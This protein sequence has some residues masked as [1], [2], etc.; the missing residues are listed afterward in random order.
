MYTL[1]PLIEKCS[2][3][4]WI[5]IAAVI[6]YVL[7]V[8]HFNGK[9]NASW[10]KSP[11]DEEDLRFTLR[12][13]NFGLFCFSF[14][15]L[16][17]TYQHLLNAVLL[18]NCAPAP[19]LGEAGRAM[20]AFAL[21]K[22]VELGDTFFLIIRGKNVR[23]IHSFHHASV[24]LLT[25]Y[26]FVSKA[27]IGPS[28]V[29]MNYFVHVMLYLYYVAASLPIGV[30]MAKKCGPVVTAMQIIQMVFGFAISARALLVKLT[31]ARPCDTS[32]A[33]AFFA[34]VVY[35]VYL[36]MFSHLWVGLYGMP[37]SPKEAKKDA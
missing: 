5:P 21:S 11:L 10:I 2:S 7:L 4:P 6:A 14:W 1:E 33:A 3:M 19:V 29:S 34:L 13:W 27:S 23:F 25:W 16:A 24:L 20:G 15:G 17:N 37:W 31:D 9:P 30:K 32:S 26:L 12:A 28:F 22:F 36:L 8:G 35:F 18:D